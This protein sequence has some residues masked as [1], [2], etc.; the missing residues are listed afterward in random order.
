MLL[1]VRERG[2]GL[3]MGGLNLGR[4]NQTAAG[5]QTPLVSVMSGQS[6][7]ADG[8]TGIGQEKN[9]IPSPALTDILRRLKPNR[10]A[11]Q[12][13]YLNNTPPAHTLSLRGYNVTYF[14]LIS[15]SHP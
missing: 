14:S 11:M 6:V 12:P 1:P 13:H 10:L 15:L 3:G 4:T 7:G 5:E 9:G 8:G 2:G